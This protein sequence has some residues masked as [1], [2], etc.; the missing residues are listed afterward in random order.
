MNDKFIRNQLFKQLYKENAK[1]NDTLI[2]NEFNVCNGLAR[3]DVAVL[4]GS[5]HGYE[6]KS[7]FDTL[8]RL[9]NQ[10]YFY[11][12]SLDRIT[13]TTTRKHLSE[14]KK[15]VPKWWGILLAIQKDNNIELKEIRKP[16]DNPEKDLNAFLEL[17]W[18]TELIQI[19][20]NNNL[21]YNKNANREKLSSVIINNLN[22]DNIYNDVRYFLKSRKSWRI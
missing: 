14:I 10:I 21:K 6:I 9:P 13:L 1:F 19:I 17:L 3:I 15:L 2:V 12:K 22:T 11:N 5:I 18:K 4:N 20:I 16:K 8:Y 7:D